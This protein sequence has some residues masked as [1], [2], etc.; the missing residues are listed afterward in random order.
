MFFD[1]FGPDKDS[2][3][4]VTMSYG[5]PARSP[6]GETS[7]QAGSVQG[8][9]K[10]T[11][12]MCFEPATAQT[13]TINTTIKMKSDQMPDEAVVDKYGKSCFSGRETWTVSR[14]G[15]LDCDEMPLVDISGDLIS[16][17]PL[18]QRSSSNEKMAIAALKTVHR[19]T[20]GRA[21]RYY[22]GESRHT[23]PVTPA[24]NDYHQR[25]LLDDREHS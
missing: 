4:E 10:P 16:G 2:V 22:G 21:G 17:P 7:R 9:D 12:K 13:L 18:L 24:N 5:I 23:F 19:R 20:K 6:S 15:A 8:N 11:I 14:S 25:D 3:G 1:A